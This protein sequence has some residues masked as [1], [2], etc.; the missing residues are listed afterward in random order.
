MSY[1]QQDIVTIMNADAS[2]NAMVDFIFPKRLAPK[3]DESANTIIVYDF[4]IE[5]SEED[6]TG[7]IFQT[8]S[9]EIYVG[10]IDY[11]TVY[12]AADRVNE[13]LKAYR[14]QNVDKLTLSHTA[15]E[16]DNEDEIYVVRLY[17]DVIYQN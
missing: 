10:G 2:L 11:D 8:W 17:F 1:F 13:Y 16:F 5:N 4:D 7:S 3:T 14:S 6:N 12:Q 15:E 9:L